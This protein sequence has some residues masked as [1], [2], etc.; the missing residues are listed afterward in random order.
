[1]SQPSDLR[2]REHAFDGLV[3]FR[4]LGGLLTRDGRRV[5]TGRVFRSDNPKSLTPEGKQQLVSVVAPS[6]VIDLRIPLEVTR[7]GYDLGEGVTL[8]NCPMTPQSGINQEQIDAGM[9][10]NLIDDYM[11]QI[12]VNG[13]FV[14]Q[15][16]G[17]IADPNSLP[18][19]I[20]CTAGKDRTGIV[21][22]MLLDLLGVEHDD[23]THDYQMTT[24]NMAPV[25]ERIRNAPVFQE[26]G[27]AY[28]P[29]WIFASDAETMEGFLARM[30][31]EFGSSEQWA[32]QQG[33]TRAQV[34]SLR[35]ELLSD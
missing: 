21:C 8:I 27:L 10:D 14:A 31:A 19:V 1:M 4:D 30:T 33:L 23:I 35:S 3:N 11:R 15:A 20:H 29:D 16:L 2:P 12:E 6:L 34:E 17:L 24:R 9:C 5:R 26:N 18:V 28:A 32:L 22:A 25:V 7:E 13:G